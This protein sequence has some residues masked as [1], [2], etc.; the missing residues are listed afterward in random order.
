MT[1]DRRPLT[2]MEAEARKVKREEAAAARRVKSEARKSLLADLRFIACF[3]SLSS[4]DERWSAAEAAHPDAPEQA[5]D[6]AMADT[7]EQARSAAV[8]CIEVLAPK[9]KRPSGGILPLED[10]VDG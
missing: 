5:T 7:P 4:A 8:A 9:R 6:L 2:A 3:P 10:G 1:A